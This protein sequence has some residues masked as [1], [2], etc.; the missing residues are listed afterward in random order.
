MDRARESTLALIAAVARQDLERVISPIMSPLAWDLG[1][2]AAYEDLWIAH[3][4]AGLD[5]LEGDLAGLYDAFETPRAV[6]GDIEALDAPAALE[7][8]A[9]V[10]R[11]TA[12]LAPA[13]DER[14][15]FI[16]EMVLRHE[17]QH[18]E[19]MRQTL[20]LGGLLDERTHV[21]ADG[22]TAQWID[23]PAG[24]FTVG[25]SEG[26]SY[27][28]ERPAFELELPAFQIAS[29][30][31]TNREW[32]QF[33]EQGGYERSEFWSDAGR[34][35]L[36]EREAGPPRS[37]VDGDPDASAVH[38]CWHEAKAFAHWAQARLPTEFEWERAARLGEREF[39][40]LEHCGEVWEW[41]DSEFD[42]YDGFS[43]EPYREYSEVF[44]ADGYRVLRGGS[45]ATDERV[46]G[47]TF[48]NWDLPI[49]SQIF[50]GVRLA[51]DAR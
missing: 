35:W 38:V 34:A 2:I 10:R 40:V 3:R 11:R 21:P 32:L 12:S 23:I 48:R 39:G 22:A 45:W 4:C 19:T 47:P 6:R 30:P 15:R 27:D 46:K 28:N 50:A 5:L 17:M 13:K 14:E 29:R 20:V 8:L 51:R 42:G 9:R 37:V 36:A 44:F 24:R 41:T 25:S 7:Y 43:A 16:W 49:R 18:C 1:H 31:A 33:T 26:F